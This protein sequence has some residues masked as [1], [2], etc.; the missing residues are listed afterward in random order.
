[1]NDNSRTPRP[2][3]PVGRALHDLARRD[4]PDDRDL[5]AGVLR[6]IEQ[7][8][9]APEQQRSW[10]GPAIDPAARRRAQPPTPPDAEEYQTMS[11]PT[12]V[13]REPVPITQRRWAREALKL[14]AAAVVFI[15]IGAVLAITLRDDDDQNVAVPPATP[16]LL[17][18]PSPTVAAQVT[19]TTAVQPSPTVAATSTVAVVAPTATSAP[20]PTS[21]ETAGLP[22]TQ[23]DA[24]T[25][26]PV[27]AY[28]ITA[29]FGSLWVP[30]GEQGVVLRIDPATL[31]TIATVAV[32]EPL[33]DYGRFGV[34]GAPPMVAVAAEDGIWVTISRGFSFAEHEFAV[35]RIDPTTNAVTQRIDLDIAPWNIASGEGSIWVTSAFDNAV[36]RIDPASGAL[37]TSIDVPAASD[38]IVAGGSVW[39]L[40]GM[41]QEPLSVVRIDPASNSVVDSLSVSW[42]PEDSGNVWGWFRWDRLAFADESLWL[43]NP[44]VENNIMRIDPQSLAVVAEITLNDIYPPMNI[45]ATDDGVWTAWDPS[46]QVVRIDP[47]A[48]AIV[49]V[50]PEQDRLNYWS[51]A[52]DEAAVYLVNWETGELAR[53]DR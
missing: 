29:G 3:R 24:T 31:E 37:L 50:Y 23:F 22:V 28:G 13:G 35:V 8:R 48:N 17:I 53:V 21:T 26:I 51:Y 9:A 20:E 19:P 16:T 15:V 41:I 14:A 33:G 11:A 52:F 46:A 47:A 39:V 2:Q 7:R 10:S 18:Q 25:T 38:V 49:A 34:P 43:S 40:S 6:A 42:M 45:A 27:H 1:M 32:M 44:Y 12:D 30:L 4:V 36:V 5:R